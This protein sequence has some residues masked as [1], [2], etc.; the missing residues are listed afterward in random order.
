MTTHAA[1]PQAP[2]LGVIGMPDIAAAAAL[3][4][5]RA[6]SDDHA[7]TALAT[8]QAELAAGIGFP[9][10]ISEHEV[11]RIATWLPELCTSTHV[12]ITTA[13]SDPAPLHALS[14]G[15]A[16]VVGLPNALADLLA[17]CGYQGLDPAWTTVTVSPAGHLDAAPGTWIEPLLAD[18]LP[19][20]NEHSLLPAAGDGATEQPPAAPAPAEVTPTQAAEVAPVDVSPHSVDT[21]PVEVVESAAA[22]ADR[23]AADQE[24]AH[25]LPQTKAQVAAQVA[26]LA[27]LHPAEPT[28]TPAPPHTVADPSLVD[29]DAMIAEL[30]G[31][32]QVVAVFAGRGGVGKTTTSFAL[33]QRAGA[34][35]LRVLLV[36]GNMWQG[37]LRGVLKVGASSL[38]SIYQAVHGDAA[39]AIIDAEHLNAARPLKLE[40]LAFSAVQAPPPTLPNPE[41]VTPALYRK[42]LGYARHHFDLIVV[43]T[44]ITE[45]HDRTGMVDHFLS[46]LLMSANTYG[47][48]ISDSSQMGVGNLLTTLKMFAHVGVAQTQLLTIMNR[49]SARALPEVSDKGSALEMRSAFLGAVAYDDEIEAYLNRGRPI[50]DLP[51]LAAM[52]DA[53]LLM[54]TSNTALFGSHTLALG[55]P[56]APAALPAAGEPKKAGRRKTSKRAAKKEAAHPP[57]DSTEAPAPATAPA[58][59][60]KGS[61]D[62]IVLRLLGRGK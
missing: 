51:T 16:Y 38:P 57:A 26:A 10:I 11:E 19:T 17:A 52:M 25:P 47:V 56:A 40:R 49:V 4:G 27:E 29:V 32:A 39:A 42:V 61:S 46:P 44:Q 3:I 45:A 37:D 35:G 7:P 23:V 53:I 12:V 50:A 1:D 2:A 18:I 21:E 59:K 30:T 13:S 41:L 28:F 22:F 36:D 14:S 31:P 34:A 60:A 48:G 58:V 5:L 24:P 55:S 6:V 15:R 9:V 33:A 43:D 8:I 62:S 54:T 20:R